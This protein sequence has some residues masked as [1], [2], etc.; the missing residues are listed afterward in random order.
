MVQTNNKTV[1]CK[2]C[3]VGLNTY[4]SNCNEH[5][6]TKR[7]VRSSEICIT[8]TLMAIFSFSSDLNH[9]VGCSSADVGCSRTLMPFFS[10]LH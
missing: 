3:F 1:C 5:V 9:H 10:N 7:R 2:L 4:F 6:T 8:F